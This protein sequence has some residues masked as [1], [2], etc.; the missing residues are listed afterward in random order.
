MS[1]LLTDLHP[2][3]QDLCAKLLRAATAQG[4]PLVLVQTYRS[5]E[6]QE[7]LYAKGR[8]RPGPIVTNARGGDSWHNYRRA[9]D[10]CFLRPLGKISWDGPWEELGELAEGLGL[11]WG[12]RWHQPDRPHFEY[13]PDLTLLQ[14]KA[15]SNPVM[16]EA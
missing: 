11:E 15:R 6:E 5:F 3:V 2:G 8:N 14:A 7:C 12:G 9:F 13:H 4:F 16:D 10:V 1:R